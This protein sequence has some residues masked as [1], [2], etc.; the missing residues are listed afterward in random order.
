MRIRLLIAALFACALLAAPASAAKPHRVADPT[1]TANGLVTRF[2]TLVQTKNQAGLNAFLSP[3]FQIQR[4]DGSRLGKAQYI[5]NLPTITNQ[6]YDNLVATAA[7]NNIV[8]TY[9]VTSDQVVNGQPYRTSPAPRISVFERDPRRGWQL[10]AH[11]NF[12]APA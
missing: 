3:D 8:A 11:G 10:V 9:T 2:L 1:A 6:S 4:A 7:G 5:A 12:N